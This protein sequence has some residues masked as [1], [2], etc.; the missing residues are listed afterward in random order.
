MLVDQDGIS[1][2]LVKVKY[3]TKNNCSEQTS[4]IHKGELGEHNG[5][6]DSKS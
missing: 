3:V 6:L 2:E 5:N 4:L 1:V